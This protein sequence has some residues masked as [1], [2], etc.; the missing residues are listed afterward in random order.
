MTAAPI[1][2]GESGSSGP[3]FG[4]VDLVY[5]IYGL[6]RTMT[7]QGIREGWFKSVLLRKPGNRSGKRLVYL[8]SVKAWLLSQMEKPKS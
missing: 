2:P 4:E 7:F 6:R 1:E 8:P 5:K 3:E